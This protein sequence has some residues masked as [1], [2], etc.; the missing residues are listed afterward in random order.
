MYL[1]D[2]RYQLEEEQ[3]AYSEQYKYALKLN[4]LGYKIDKND[5]IDCEKVFLFKEKINLLKDMIA[6]LIK[7]ERE[8]IHK[9]N[10]KN[11]A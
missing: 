9:A 7:K 5:L 8:K 11:K 4:N 2:A 6:D 10:L 3:L 1:Q